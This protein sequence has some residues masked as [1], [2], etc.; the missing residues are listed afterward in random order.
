MIKLSGIPPVSSRGV[1]QAKL[2]ISDIEKNSAIVD[3]KIIIH[4]NLPKL[5]LTD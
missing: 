1:W 3:L 4:N 2:L 5:N